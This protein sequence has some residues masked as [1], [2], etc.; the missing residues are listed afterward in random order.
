MAN[1]EFTTSVNDC[2][3]QANQK[4]F[5][6]GKKLDTSYVLVELM[7]YS[8]GGVTPLLKGIG[9]DT[10]KLLVAVRNLQSVAPSLQDQGNSDKFSDGFLQAFSAATDIAQKNNSTVIDMNNLLLAISMGDDQVATL[11]NSMDA[12]PKKIKMA[13][14]DSLSSD[15]KVSGQGHYP[16][17]LE[18]GRDMTQMAREGL[19]DPV[20]GRETE[21]RRVME[22]LSRRTKNNPVI[23]GE[24]GVGK[25]LSDDTLVP[26]YD[27]A[28]KVFYKN[29]G[30]LQ[31]GDFIFDRY[32]NPTKVVGV[33]PQG[34]Q[35]VFE[36]HLKNRGYIECNDEH[37]WTYKN[38]KG[39]DP[40][41]K[42]NT[43]T[44]KEIVAK[45]IFRP[46]R[47]G[48][49]LEAKYAIPMNGSVQWKEIDFPLDPYVLGAFIGNG[50]LRSKALCFS[51]GTVDIPENVAKIL[52]YDDKKQHNKNYNYNFLDKDGKKIKT[53][54]VFVGIAAGLIDS[55]SHEKFIPEE[56][57]YG[58]VEQRW[59]LIQGLFDTD[60]SINDD[61]K[62]FNV[63]Y[64]TVS[65][66]LA[67]D[68]QTVLRGLGIDSSI[69]EYSRDRKYVNGENTRIE[70]NL[71]VSVEDEK[72]PLFFK[73][74]ERKI[75]V[76]R[77]SV[78]NT[79][80]IQRQYDKVL[81]ENVIDT[82]KMKPMTC[83]K[84]DNDEQLY[85]VG[86]Q[87]VVTHNTSVVEGLAQKIV[88]NDCP[89]QLK[90]KTL[91]SLDLAK[92][93]AGAS[94]KGQ[95]EER[96]RDILEEIKSSDGQV[97]TFIDE[98]HMIAADSGSP[99][100]LA[101]MMKEYL[102]RGVLKLVGATTLDEFRQYLEKDPALDRRFQKVIVNEPDTED[103]IAILRGVKE[104]YEAHH[105]IM[106]TDPALISCVEL[107]QRYITNRFLPDKAIDLLDEACAKLKIS[108]STAPAII[109]E[110]SRKLANLETEKSA[111]FEE[112]TEVSR[113]RIQEIN[114][115]LTEVR[116]KLSQEKAKWENDQAEV[117][118]VSQ[119]RREIE[120]EKRNEKKFSAEADWGASAQA[121]KRIDDLQKELQEVEEEAKSK[122]VSSRMVAQQVTPEIISE[123]V[124]SWTGVPASKM[125]ASETE[126][127]LAMGDI[128]RERVVGQDEAIAALVKAVKRS[129]SGV[130]DP[131]KPSSFMFAG[132]SGAGKSELSKALAEFLYDDERALITF[133]MSEYTDKTSVNK[134]VGAS[135]G[136][137]GYDSRP[138][139]EA[140]RDAGSAV[141]LFDEAE[142]ADV[143][144]LLTLLGAMEEGRLTLS[145]GKE[146]DFKNTIMIFTTNAGAPK[147]GVID[148]ER[149]MEEVRHHEKFRPEFLNRLDDIIIFNPLSIDALKD[150]ANIQLKKLERVISHTRLTLSLTDS[151]RNRIA[152][153]GYDPAYGG[154]VVRRI[155]SND[156]ADLISDAII[157]GDITPGSH[158]IIDTDAPFVEPE[159]DLNDEQLLEY[160]NTTDF[161][162]F[163]LQIDEEAVEDG[164]DSPIDP[165]EEKKKEEDKVREK[166]LL[167]DI[168]S[169]I[170]EGTVNTDDEEDNELAALFSD[171]ESDT[172]DEEDDI[173]SQLVS[174]KSSNSQKSRSNF[175]QKRSPFDDSPN[176]KTN[177]N[178]KS[179][180]LG[181]DDKDNPYSG[182]G[183]DLED[184]FDD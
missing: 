88:D 130:K 20:V 26:V 4:A 57:K 123:V 149:A 16:T 125:N 48:R 115:E 2:V 151:A 111:L 91:I 169:A 146:V 171:E 8:D 64:S 177:K 18:Y 58:S 157:M 168:N 121:K 70:Y 148:K 24:P 114:E 141:L 49:K 153:S 25:A 21:T 12:T 32:G 174:I 71:H 72:K 144:V 83:I 162:G 34:E 85:Q 182:E 126:R 37:L 43:A 1:S 136:F 98:I 89:E 163:V 30:D 110:L 22:I 97:I 101:N 145:N 45:G 84:V 175:D 103:A 124:S 134:L 179:N 161:P 61:G 181:Q 140:V 35:R 46:Q 107:S 5:Q 9:V 154:R 113:I 93:N 39:N 139:L 159:G 67:E 51:S 7:D 23:V 3:Q 127:I 65:K 36:V 109:D 184:L 55:Y 156:I 105:G 95:F 54:D 102:A 118:K 17:L 81:I 44:L 172:D 142:K 129:R 116:E 180:G 79:K 176:E 28:G 167:A 69:K 132:S 33:Y 94:Y 59:S 90:G 106:V 29:H 6:G 68:I 108:I 135:A 52:G 170:N 165:D 77:K 50:A 137:I 147:D 178:D 41:Y 92:L 164:A 74:S 158:I 75:E 100:N 104:K 62:R 13:I 56:Y 82:G 117:E 86:T 76:A 80:S 11:M 138:A 166:N 152:Y 173:L 122:G 38:A 99:M 155:V 143:T 66:Q 15:K 73:Y 53:S 160:I 14:S 133:D 131:N 150:I 60:G 96:V 87:H 19:M 120:E 40:K 183:I 128:L 42:W 27:T 78:E 10:D 47:E 63:T 112:N 31:V 119:I